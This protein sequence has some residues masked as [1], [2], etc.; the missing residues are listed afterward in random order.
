LALVLLPVALALAGDVDDWSDAPP[1][2]TTGLD[3]LAF[4]KPGEWTFEADGESAAAGAGAPEQRQHASVAAIF[5][6]AAGNDE[7]IWIKDG[8]KPDELTSLRITRGDD[9]V[10]VF[11][12]FAG[13]TLA[14]WRKF[15]F[16]T[17]SGL[18]RTRKVDATHCRENQPALVEVDN[19][20]GS[21]S[22]GNSVSRA[23]L[24]LAGDNSLIVRQDSYSCWLCLQKNRT[25]QF[26]R[27]RAIEARGAATVPD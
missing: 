21:W 18:L 19:Y 24:A 22:G 4:C 27:F 2:W 16:V 11:R 12:A 5:F 15:Q 1:V 14:V 17:S 20:V 23:R 13:K 9:G 26:A 7:V 6:R 25:R 3:L 10:L 8:P